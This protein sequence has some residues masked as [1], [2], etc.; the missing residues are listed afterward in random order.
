MSDEIEDRPADV[1]AAAEALTVGL[2]AIV[3]PLLGLVAGGA[4]AYRNNRV[5]RG[6]LD[7]ANAT[8]ERHG[9]L[10]DPTDDLAIAVFNRLSI[11]AIQTSRHDKWV[12]LSEALARSGQSAGTP[13]FVQ[14]MFAELVVRYTPEHVEMLYLAAQ[15]EEWL[16]ERGLTVGR[17][18][19]L[20]EILPATI[21]ASIDDVA[22]VAESIWRELHYDGMIMN[23]PGPAMNFNGFAWAVTDQGR[24]FLRHLGKT[25]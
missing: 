3:N 4:I 17:A 1:E 24:R 22:L 2:A 12:Y 16:A 19:T 23:E 10:L 11:G 25:A 20:G 18:D 14:E 8:L 7:Q 21:L 15:P 6:W 5:I 9:R 13:D